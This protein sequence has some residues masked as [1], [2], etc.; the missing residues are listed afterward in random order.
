MYEIVKN[1]IGKDCL[2]Y[3]MNSQVAGTITEVADGWLCI[4]NG[5]DTDAVNVDYIV[6]IREYPKNKKGARK[7]IVTD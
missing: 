4:E 3:T 2:I 7:S 5:K 1:F 6:R